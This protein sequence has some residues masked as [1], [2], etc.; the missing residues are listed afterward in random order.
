MGKHT[1]WITCVLFALVGCQGDAG[2]VGAQGE[3]GAAGANGQSCWDT[4]HDGQCSTG[5]DVDQSG[6]C[7]K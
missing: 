4:N 5:E 7:D 6:S 1:Y 2:S 3:K